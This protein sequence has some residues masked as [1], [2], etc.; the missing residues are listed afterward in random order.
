MKKYGKRVTATLM[1]ALMLTSTGPAVWAA[2]KQENVESVLSYYQN[3]DYTAKPMARMWFPDATAG[4]DDEDVYKRQCVYGMCTSGGT[5]S[6]CG[7]S[8]SD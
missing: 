1:A 5:W 3:P 4:M 7:T 2:E 6:E 8:G